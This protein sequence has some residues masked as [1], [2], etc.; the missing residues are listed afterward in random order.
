MAV[1]I[2][3]VEVAGGQGTRYT[4]T[5][6]APFDVY[7][8][9]GEALLLQ[10]SATELTLE[11]EGETE[12]PIIEVRDADSTGTAATAENPAWGMLQWRGRANVDRWKVEYYT[13]SAWA[14]ADGS[15]VKNTGRGY[16]QFRTPVL[17]DGTAAQYRVVPVD[18]RDYEG[19]SQAF[20][21]TVIRNP[22]PPAVAVSWDKA[23]SQ[24]VVAAG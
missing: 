16:Y 17:A 3:A 8:A 15:P 24:V 12:P 21:F 5:G 19:D 23:G 4:W 2:T 22:E 10:T 7:G 14:E 20:S 1:A 18:A 13:G 6:T 9:D 11:H